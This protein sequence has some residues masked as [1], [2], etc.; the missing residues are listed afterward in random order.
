M[1]GLLE[2]CR[3]T[4]CRMSSRL[5][6]PEVTV[7]PKSKDYSK[8]VTSPFLVLTLSELGKG[9]GLGLERRKTLEVVSLT[10]QFVA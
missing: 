4:M 3:K 8:T 5:F 10:P 2:T 9:L 6:S 7:Q 1:G